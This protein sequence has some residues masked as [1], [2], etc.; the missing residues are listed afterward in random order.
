ME[1][2]YIKYVQKW[3]ITV[4]MGLQLWMKKL[5]LVKITVS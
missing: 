1:N 5:L 2:I 3:I 4:M